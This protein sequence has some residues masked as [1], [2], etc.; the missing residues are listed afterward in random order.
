MNQIILDLLDVK[1]SQLCLWR[2]Y[3]RIVQCKSAD[4]SV[5]QVTRSSLAW[6]AAWSWRWRRN[7]PPKLWLTCT[8]LYGAVSPVRDPFLCD[9]RHLSPEWRSCVRICAKRVGLVFTSLHFRTFCVCQPIATLL[10]GCC[11]VRVCVPV[12]PTRCAS[13]AWMSVGCAECCRRARPQR[14][15]THQHT[16]AGCHS[17]LPPGNWATSNTGHRFVWIERVMDWLEPV[18]RNKH[19]MRFVIVWFNV[20]VRISST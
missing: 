14:S 7:I 12:S 11:L 6:L 19:V 4:V 8:R 16:W 2:I 1:F 3:C 15:V 5:E 13:P 10:A 9:F 18:L 20:C 17:V